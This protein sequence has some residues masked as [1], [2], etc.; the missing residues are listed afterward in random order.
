MIKRFLLLTIFSLTFVFIGFAGEAKTE[1]DVAIENQQ[2]NEEEFSEKEQC[3]AKVYE[4][5]GDTDSSLYKNFHWEFMAKKFND[6]LIQEFDDVKYSK[7]EWGPAV[8][9]FYILFLSLLVK[10]ALISINKKDDSSGVLFSVFLI[11][12]IDLPCSIGIL[13][14]LIADGPGAIKTLIDKRD[15]KTLKDFLDNWPNNKK[16]TPEELHEFFD[17]LY[18]LNN[19]NSLVESE[20]VTNIVESI[21]NLA[22]RKT[23]T[24]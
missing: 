20:V 9:L 22:L 13:V 7:P 8:G 21:R 19:D 12:F 2:E 24:A 10:S 3:V 16:I 1:K 14:A 17:G 15:Y 6:E 4:M 11:F 18:E 5:F 23:K